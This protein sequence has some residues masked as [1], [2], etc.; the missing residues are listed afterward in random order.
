MRRAGE[1]INIIYSILLLIAHD[2]VSDSRRVLPTRV[3]KRYHADPTTG[4]VEYKKVKTNAL[5]ASIQLG[6]RLSVSSISRAKKRDLLYNDF[7]EVES[8][9]FPKNGSDITPPHHF[10]S[11]KF[12]SYAPFAFRLF[13]EEFDI[14]TMD[15]MVSLC[16]KPLRPLAN[17]GAGG[18][19][20]YLTADDQFIIKTVHKDEHKF[21]M[22]LLSGYY[23]NLVQ[24]KR[25]LLPKFF[26]LFCYQSIGKNIRFVV[27]NNLLP[28]RFKYNCRFD[29]KG[30]SHNRF[31]S[32]AECKKSSPTFKGELHDSACLFANSPR[33][34]V[35]VAPFFVSQA[36]FL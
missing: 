32:D 33:V 31:A 27:M 30:S 25:T 34:E 35:L 10:D 15:F 20:F 8:T 16:D 21:M 18:S 29:L 2:Y 12:L 11:F 28:S 5:S 24:N 4:E 3:G 7:E 23:I 14:N 9:Y 19:V 36:A 17:P 6:L 13:R 26:G 1:F 22:R